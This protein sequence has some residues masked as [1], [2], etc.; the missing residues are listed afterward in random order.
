MFGEW[1]DKRARRPRIEPFRQQL[2]PPV[3]PPTSTTSNVVA[4]LTVPLLL[5]LMAPPLHAEGAPPAGGERKAEPARSESF[6]GISA[7]P[8]ASDETFGAGLSSGWRPSWW[9]FSVREN[10]LLSPTRYRS[11]ENLERITRRVSFEMY[12]EAELHAGRFVLYAGPGGAIRTD[13]LE[14]ISVMAN[15]FQQETSSRTLVRPVL[16]L[17]LLDRFVDINVNA[18][19]DGQGVDFRFGLGVVAG[20]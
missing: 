15:A 18:F 7:F 12:W 3:P 20:R 2:T 11:A 17:G 14:H 5:L 6:I 19:F 8:L 4:R 1:V 10:F 13:K 16:S 9:A